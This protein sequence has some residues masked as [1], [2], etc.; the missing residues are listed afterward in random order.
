M[1]ARPVRFDQ[2]IPSIVERDAVSYHT[3]E[4][5]QVLRGM[6]FVS[7]IYACNWGPGL[8]G[9]VSA[10]DALP[11]EASGQWVCYQAS[12]GS[13]AAE[14]VLDHP[15]RVV[16]NYHNI[17]PSELVSRFMPPLGEEVRLGREQLAA[18]APVSEAGI[19]VSKFNTSELQAWGFRRTAVAGLM[20]DQGSFERS[21]DR[22]LSEALDARKDRGGSDWLFV[23]Q[24]L[25]H[26]GQ[27]DVLM[28]FA[29][30]LESYDPRAR[31]HLVGRPSCGEYALALRRLAE[32][33]GVAESV[34]F[35]GSVS[36][37]ELASYYEAADVFVCCSRHEG[38]CA[39][40]LEAMYHGIPVV[41]VDAGAVAETVLDAGVVVPDARPFL[42]AAA[43][44]RALNDAELRAAIIDRGHDRARTFTNAAARRAFAAAVKGSLSA[45]GEAE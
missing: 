41:A 29:C 17:T 5:Q 32:Q 27:A 14:A 3:L 7:E 26:K 28:A 25:P 15:G 31:L 20:M 13:P 42:V 40:L 1:A 30:Y 6:G 23:G 10:I 38:F 2:V 18:L 19:G 8:D 36:P 11:R 12:I 16:V 45:L 9:R 33:A 24:M 4:A 43:A 44:H 35:A 39:P 34:N 22:R 21:A 37:A